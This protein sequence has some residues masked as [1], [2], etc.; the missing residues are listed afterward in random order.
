MD[1][2]E[3]KRGSWQNNVP[4]LRCVAGTTWNWHSIPW[5]CCACRKRGL[6]KILRAKKKINLFINFQTFLKMKT[7]V[8]EQ[9]KERIVS[10]VYH[11]PTG[12]SG[13]DAVQ[14]AVNLWVRNLQ[15]CPENACLQGKWKLQLKICQTLS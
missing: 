5:V 14:T 3:W 4:V 6:W 11:P 2:V 12:T 10:D 13:V 15:K 7:E 1:L 9:Q 8:L